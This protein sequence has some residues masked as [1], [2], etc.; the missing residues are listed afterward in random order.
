M[1]R[2]FK[3]PDIPKPE[4]AP[5]APTIDDAQSRLDDQERRRLRRGRAANN[6][7]ERETNVSTAARTLTGN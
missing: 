4:P 6:M 3:T 1:S 5:P 7:V 2:L